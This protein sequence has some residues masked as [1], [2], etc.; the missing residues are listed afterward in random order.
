M[1]ENQQDEVA[2]DVQIVQGVPVSIVVCVG[3]GVL[4]PDAPKGAA[5]DVFLHDG[6]LHSLILALIARCGVLGKLAYVGALDAGR[7]AA[8]NAEKEKE[9]EN[10][11]PGNSN[12]VA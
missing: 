8:Q 9:K 3:P 2:N 6:C 1:A 11:P 5:A 7:Q 10:A 4:Q 12:L